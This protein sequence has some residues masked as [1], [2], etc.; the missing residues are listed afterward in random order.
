MKITA[1]LLRSKGACGDQVATFATE[2]PDGTELTMAAAT[3][4]VELRL[5]LG[6]F[7]ETFLTAAARAEYDKVTAAAW[8]E[9]DKVKAAARA[10][11]DKVTAPARAEYNKVTAPA[12][13]AAWEMQCK[14]QADE[15]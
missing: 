9:Y 3:R 10:E 2:W 8:A 5:D 12:L 6:W 15:G 4:S 1:E 11:Y 14:E 13:A 7:A